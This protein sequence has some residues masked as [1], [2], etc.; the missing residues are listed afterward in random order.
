MASPLTSSLSP[1]CGNNY[2]KI[3]VPVILI[4][5]QII[6]LSFEQFLLQLDW[7]RFMCCFEFPRFSLFPVLFGLSD[8]LYVRSMKIMTL[9]GYWLLFQTTIPLSI[10]H[11]DIIISNITVNV[12]CSLTLI[13]LTMCHLNYF[14]VAVRRE[15]CENK[16]ETL[17][18]CTDSSPCFFFLRVTDRRPNCGL[19]TFSILNNG[20]PSS[21]SNT[22]VLPNR[23]LVSKGKQTRRI[24]EEIW[25]F[26]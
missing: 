5:H 13:E 24:Y 9:P 6:L 16:L 3:V 7:T 11:V 20:I 14:S 21:T 10:S 22:I 26:R 1:S 15:A 17:F 19:I 18:F 2:T 12:W 25:W 4:L 23:E 8:G